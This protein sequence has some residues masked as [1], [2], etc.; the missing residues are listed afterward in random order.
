ME[1]EQSCRHS[2]QNLPFLMNFFT[3]LWKTGVRHTMLMKVVV[4]GK[5]CCHTQAEVTCFHSLKAEI[6]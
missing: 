2:H 1:T 4:A 6:W 5:V 3:L